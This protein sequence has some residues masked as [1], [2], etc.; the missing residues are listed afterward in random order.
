MKYPRHLWTGDWRSESEAVRS[1]RSRERERARATSGPEGD[2]PED[3]TPAAE[4]MPGPAPRRDRTNTIRLGAALVLVA[5]A[6]G[7]AFAAGAIFGDGGN[8]SRIA[9]DNV[10]PLPAITRKPIKPTQGRTRAGT[11]YAMDSPAV[12]SLRTSEGSGTG[13]LIDPKGTLVTNAHVVGQAKGIT[14]RFG[15]RGRNLSGQ[16][17][18]SDP[19]SDLAVVKIDE[20]DV[21][22]GVKPLR[23]ADSRD[24]RVG[25]DVIAIGNPFGLD[26][27]ETRGIV[28]AIHRSIQ[29]PNNF[30]IDDAIQTDAAINPGNSGGPL[31]DDTGRVIGVNS[32]I[33]TSG[34]QGNVGV[35]FAVPANSVRQVVPRLQRGQK[36]A[37][38]WLGVETRSSVLGG[39]GA[40][41]ASVVAGGPAEKAGFQQGDVLVRVDRGSIIDSPD[42]ARAVNARQ[43]GDR[44]AVE[45]NRAGRRVTI[46]VELGLRPTKVP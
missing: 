35:G 38:P 6:V 3:A 11:I 44:V 24:V 45:V 10:K 15:Q 12:V 26:R 23:L 27:T 43:P 28:S 8:G 42:V 1:A 13:F 29:A 21:P 30:Q 9:N 41:V 14:V 16:V 31:L 36:I 25:D 39:S 7:V 5:I 34:S 33:E 22:G 37:R 18:A 40:E 32:Q 19:S 20:G 4:Q 17:L 2:A 46:H